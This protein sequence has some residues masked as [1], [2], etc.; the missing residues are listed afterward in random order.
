[1]LIPLK[2]TQTSWIKKTIKSMTPEEKVAQVMSWSGGHLSDQEILDTL[3][4]IPFGGLFMNYN[5]VQRCKEVAD[6]ISGKTKIPIITCADLE[7]GLGARMDGGTI[8]P[9]LMGCGACDSEYLVEEMGVATA[10]EGR[11]CGIH[12][13]LGPVVDL[14]IN[15][16]NGMSCIRSFGENP[17]H[18]IRMANAFIRGVQKN[19]LM[20]ATA[21]HF[22]GDGVDDR[23][24][25]VC[26][27]INHL[28]R[29]DWQ[30]SFG[31][32]WK[33]VIDQGVMTVM[34]GHIGLPFMDPG[35][36]A[37]LGPTPAT[38]SKKIQIDLL[39]KE[40]G[41]DGLIVSDAIPMAGFSTH[42]TP[43][44]RAADN[45]NAG[46]DMVLWARPQEDYPWMCQA[47]HD[48]KVSS[49]RLNDAVRR[50]LELKARIGLL[51]DAIDIPKIKRDDKIRFEECSESIAEKSISIIRNENQLIPLHL[52]EGARVLTVSCQFEEKLRGTVQELDIVDL[53]LRKRGFQVDHLKNPTG[54]ELFEKAFD[55]DAVFI[56]IHVL[57]RYGS[58]FMTDIL[59]R[60]FWDSFWPEHPCV[61][62]SSFGDP[63]KIYEL[64]SVPNM[65]NVYG[66][67]PCS[68]RA[69][70]KV[71]FGEIPAQGK[72]P[73]KL[74]GF[75]ETEVA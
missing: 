30:Q 38:L 21:K 12:W 16:H 2:K 7:N 8:F 65:V 11:N 67:S 54:H 42:T 66:S 22:P 48:G 62:F 64:P 50:V 37:F 75:F 5:T 44:M 53:E 26:T 1:M 58:I 56:N 43:H 17:Q 70:V 61:V 29:N 18:V 46:S 45:I 32:V 23:D 34:S 10:V 24:P 33:A 4:R 41:F 3:E 6:L 60:I 59:A 71:W 25:H 72:N 49:E 36:K 68:Q 51:D 39:R 52:A 9:W 57:C 74:D 15:H 20:A 27:V 31:N 28:R 13:T 35:L 73:V 69:A 14:N 47:V 55:Y 19:R 63:Y 40:L